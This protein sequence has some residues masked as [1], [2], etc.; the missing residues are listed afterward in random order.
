MNLFIRDFPNELHKALKIQAAQ[1]SQS[2]GGLIIEL[3]KTADNKQKK[4]DGPKKKGKAN[5]G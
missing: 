5:V 3:L 4:C 2:L 1:L